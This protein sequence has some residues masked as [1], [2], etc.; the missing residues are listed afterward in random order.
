MRRYVYTNDYGRMLEFSSMS[1]FNLIQI[2]GLSENDITITEVSGSSQ[3]GSTATNKKIEPKSITFEGDYKASYD[4]R[5]TLIDTIA[6]GV[7][8]RIRIIDDEI[9]LDVYI[10]GTP[11]KTPI[12][13]NEKVYQK[14]QFVFHCPF[15]FW[16]M[17]TEQSVSFAEY[18]SHFRFPRS[19]SNTVSWR[20]SDRSLLLIENIRNEG[21]LKTG[22]TVQFKAT[23]EVTSPE[24]LKISTQEKIKMKSD[25]V[26]QAGDIVEISTYDDKK[27]VTLTRASDGIAVN[28]FK[29]L[30]DETDFFQ[31][32]P[33][34]NIIRY[35]A[36][37]NYNL[38]EVTVISGITLA[39]V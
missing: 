7:N 30:S 34:D 13:S 4:N 18:D 26:M 22:F 6:P 33:G 12:L 17:T 11:T 27:R 9:G 2:D 28:G 15:P 1:G 23:G 35:G 29:Y 19:F 37:E 3:I 5:R 25:F 21:T 36:D 16:T 31:L 24:L 32:D 8:A 20:I 38:L 39:G 10:E 14:F